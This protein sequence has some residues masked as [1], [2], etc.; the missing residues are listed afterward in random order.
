M[1]VAEPV[2]RATF[3]EFSMSRSGF[4]R[5]V[6]VVW[7]SSSSDRPFCRRAPQDPQE[8]TAEAV[9]C[10]VF[11]VMWQNFQFVHYAA[12]NYA[13]PC[14]LLKVT[15]SQGLAM[16]AAKHWAYGTGIAFLF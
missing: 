6:V 12:R 9:F 16:I 15:Y 10:T 3:R 1:P 4:V 5:G 8:K 11:R 14:S 13:S 7:C 2:T